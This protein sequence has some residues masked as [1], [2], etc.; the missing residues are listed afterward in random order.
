MLI[1]LSNCLLVHK[2]LKLQLFKLKF[3]LAI[4]QYVHRGC[5]RNVEPT[6]KPSFIL[7]LFVIIHILEIYY[8]FCFW[9]WANLK[10]DCLK[11]SWGWSWTDIS[12]AFS[13][14]AS[15][16]KLLVSNVLE[17]L[18]IGILAWVVLSRA[19]TTFLV[20][21]SFSIIVPSY[22]SWPAG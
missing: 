21:F 15:S 16:F 22:L 12:H 1:W 7:V 2:Q 8:K 19:I 18:L 3:G 13:D 20:P 10:T 11:K 14:Q 4:S 6:V 17:V 9:Y 5:L